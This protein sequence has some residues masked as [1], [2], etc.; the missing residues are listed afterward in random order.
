MKYNPFDYAD[1]PQY[2]YISVSYARKLQNNGIEIYFDL[3]EQKFYW[4]PSVN[5]HLYQYYRMKKP[6]GTIHYDTVFGGV[7]ISRNGKLATRDEFMMIP[8]KVA[9]E[10]LLF[11]KAMDEGKFETLEFRD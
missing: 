2:R 11:C 8:E 1:K 9:R 7:Y 5:F 4:V 6:K 10:M 3:I